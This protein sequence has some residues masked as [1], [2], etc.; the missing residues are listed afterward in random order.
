MPIYTSIPCEWAWGVIRN[1]L[2]VGEE[3]AKSAKSVK[4]YARGKKEVK[5]YHSFFEVYTIAE[6]TARTGVGSYLLVQHHTCWG[7]AVFEVLLTTVPFEV[8]SSHVCVTRSRLI[9]RIGGGWKSRSQPW[10]CAC[11]WCV[12]GS[13]FT[14]CIGSL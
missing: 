1:C 13:S 5:Q 7:A 6:Q 2:A 11:T 9:R 14:R 3:S 12:C 4:R 8:R 10:V